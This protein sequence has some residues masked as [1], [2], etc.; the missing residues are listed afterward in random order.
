MKNKNYIL[1]IGASGHGQVIADIAFKMNQWKRIVFLDDNQEIQ[2][3]MGIEVIGKT[4]ELDMYIEDYDLFVGIGDNE[5]REK[6]QKM[7]E[8]RGASIPVLVH[9]EAVIGEQ[10][11]LGAGTAVMAGAIINCNTVIGKG[12]IINTGSTIDHDN[13]I[14]D[15]VHISPGSNLAGNVHVGRETWIGIGSSVSNNLTIAKKCIIGA[16]AVVINDIYTSGTYIGVPAIKVEKQRILILAN[17]GYTLY[18]L[19]NQLIKELINNGFNVVIALP[20][21]EYIPQLKQMGCKYINIDKQNQNVTTDLQLFHTYIKLITKLRPKMV[22]TYSAKSNII[23]GFACRLTNTTYIANL[24]ELGI[25]KKQNELYAN[26]IMQLYKMSLKKASCVFFQ[27]KTQQIR[28]RAK[29]IIKGNSHLI[30][31]ILPAN[32]NIDYVEYPKQDITTHILYVGHLEKKKGIGELLEAVISL[33]NKNLLVQLDIVGEG[34][35]EYL[36]KVIELESLGILTYQSNSTNLNELL[37]N[38]HA[39]VIPSYD[40]SM[41]NAIILAQAVGRPVIISNLIGYKEMVDQN[42]DGLYFEAKNIKSLVDVLEEFVQL[43]YERKKIMGING[44]RKIESELEY[45]VNPY[46]TEINRC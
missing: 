8:G 36:L 17:D 2:S 9:P 13:V 32:N 7:L 44:R 38:S 34:S 24:I 46:I 14:E 5:T 11:T 42:Y 6:F 25:R 40:E 1:I 15:Y 20:Y 33:K 37:K 18:K 27:S 22:F 28:F 35:E 31:G 29:K 21:D 4:G 39:V 10:V 19:R 45:T 12:C 16:G 41:V 30:P 23:G 43:P 26:F 3:P